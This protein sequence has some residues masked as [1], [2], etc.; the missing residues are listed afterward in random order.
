MMLLD[1]ITTFILSVNTK[2]ANILKKIN[3]FS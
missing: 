2:N 3:K 1:I